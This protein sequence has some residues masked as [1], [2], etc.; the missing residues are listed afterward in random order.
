MYDQN[1]SARALLLD[2]CNEP[3]PGS[4]DEPLSNDRLKRTNHYKQ[5]KQGQ[6]VHTSYA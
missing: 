3:L 1:Q 6:N 2:A 5:P 4:F